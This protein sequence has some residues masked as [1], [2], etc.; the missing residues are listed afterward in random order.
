[1]FFVYSALRSIIRN[2]EYLE[3]LQVLELYILLGDYSRIQLSRQSKKQF[4]QFGI[5][6]R[7]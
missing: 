4:F 7:A 3:F 2:L 6:W 1:M 5:Y